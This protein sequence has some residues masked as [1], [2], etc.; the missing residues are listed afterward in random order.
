M[1]REVFQAV[2]A[3]ESE[4]ELLIQT[5]QRKARELLKATE[6]DITENERAIMLE[7]RAMYQTILDERRESVRAQLAANH[8]AV[9]TAQDASLAD[10]RRRLDDVAGRIFERVLNDGHC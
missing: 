3:A 6:T 5:A 7:H 8:L 9:V 4:A 2:Q 1:S 10:A